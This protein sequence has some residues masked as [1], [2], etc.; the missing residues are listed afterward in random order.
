MLQIEDLKGRSLAWA[1]ATTAGWES[2]NTDALRKIRF[3]EGQEHEDFMLPESEY[4]IT[5]TPGLLS[6]IRDAHGDSVK[7][8]EGW[9]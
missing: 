4:D 9:S 5:L 7:V 2:T 8:P 1:L 3:E 6:Q